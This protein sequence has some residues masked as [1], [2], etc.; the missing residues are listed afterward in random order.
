MSKTARNDEALNAKI[1][2]TVKRMYLA[3]DGETSLTRQ[4]QPK[5]VT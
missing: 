2:A 3:A 4:D 5:A 1:L